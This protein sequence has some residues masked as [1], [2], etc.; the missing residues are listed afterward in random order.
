M[1]GTTCRV[2]DWRL[3][4]NTEEREL[5]Q[6]KPLRVLGRCGHVLKHGA[7]NINEIKMVAPTGFEP[8]FES[9]RA[10]AKVVGNLGR[11]EY[12]RKAQALKRAA[13]F[14]REIKGLAAG[15][16]RQFESRSGASP[17]YHGWPER[18]YG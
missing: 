8:V 1:D 5:N 9:R 10:F 3:E 13:A 7:L 12:T 14:T 11:V 6:I 18:C 2:S 17:E 16:K 15:M 4:S